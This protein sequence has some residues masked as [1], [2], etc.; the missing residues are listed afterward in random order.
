MSGDRLRGR[1]AIVTG[2]ARGQGEAHV[3]ALAAEGANVLCTDVLYAEGTALARELGAT[4]KFFKHDVTSS[5]QWREAVIQ[6]EK[7]FGP[8]SILVNN[9]GIVAMASIEEMTE[10]DYRQIIDV[11]QLGVFLEI[12]RAHV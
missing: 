4:V 8:V 11:N 6:A 9:A 1:A 3:R 7:D 12:G 5:E 10:Q 2:G